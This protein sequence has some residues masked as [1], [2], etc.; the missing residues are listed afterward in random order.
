MTGDF[1]RKTLKIS[2]VH[3]FDSLQFLRRLQKSSINAGLTI[4]ADSRTRIFLSV[5]DKTYVRENKAQ[6]KLDIIQ[7]LLDG[8]RFDRSILPNISGIGGTLIY[9]IG[10]PVVREKQI[11]EMVSK[12]LETEI[13]S[14]IFINLS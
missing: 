13:N 8:C 6:T 5:Y 1:Q 3:N 11:E 2:G 7:N 12:L 10:I 4:I 9:A 14:C